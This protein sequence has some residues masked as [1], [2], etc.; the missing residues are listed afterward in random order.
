MINLN[1]KKTPDR[2]PDSLKIG[3]NSLKTVQTDL[4]IILSLFL[5]LLPDKIFHI[6]QPGRLQQ[7]L[8]VEPGIE[9]GEQFL[10]IQYQTI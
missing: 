2:I 3:H 7:A 9:R 6:I 4:K 1:C 10:W 5:P 8:P